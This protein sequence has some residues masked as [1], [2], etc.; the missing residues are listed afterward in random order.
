[1]KKAILPFLIIFIFGMIFI[2]WNKQKSSN[3]I[4]IGNNLIQSTT[5]LEK[6]TE[7]VTISKSHEK[8][9]VN[10]KITKNE[11]KEDKAQPGIIRALE[12]RYER[13][14]DPATGQIPS[15]INSKVAHFL[16]YQSGAIPDYTN[17]D[18]NSNLLSLPEWQKVGPYNIGG[19]TRALAIDISDPE[20]K[21]ILAGAVSGGMWK[22]TDG[23]ITWKRTTEP[24]QLGS[25][26]CI[27]QN[28]HIGKENIWY[29]GTGELWGN[30]ANINGDG[31]FKS[32]DGGWT[33]QQIPS[34]IRNTPNSWDNQFEFI[35]N[36]LIYPKESKDD[37]IFAA[38]AAGGII[39]ST[40]GGKT[41]NFVLGSFGNNS[42]LFTDIASTSDGVLYATLS[43]E[44]FGR[45][46]AS[47]YGIFRSVNGTDWV[48]ITPDNFPE[49]YKRIV[50]GISPSDENQVYFLAETPYS[51]KQTFNTQGDTLWHSLFK[52][53][54][55]SGDGKGSGGQWEDRSQNLPKPDYIRGQFNSQSSYNLVI[56]VKPDNPDIV[57]IGGTNLY[58][59]DDGFKT[60]DRIKW[61]G[62]YCPLGFN[63]KDIYTY[64]NQHA[65]QHA[66][67]FPNNSTIRMYA[68]TDGG[69]SVTENCAADSVEWVS[70]NQGYTTTQFY[71][72]AID[73]GTPGS[74]EII[75][76]TQDNGTL[77]ANNK[78]DWVFAANADG[79]YCAI[80]NGGKYH[81]TSNNS[82]YQPKIRIWRRVLDENGEP[83]ITTRLDPIGGQDFI[84][85]TPF[86]LDP[87]NQN[88]MY[89]AG[90]K[91]VWRN[92]DLSKIPN[93]KNLDSISTEW[94]SLSL[95]RVE[96]ENITALG[97]SKIPANTLY[98][99]TSTGKLFKIKD[100]HIGNPEPEDITGKNFPTNATIGCIAVDPNDGNKIFT[101]FTNYNVE[102]IFYSEDE[103]KT[104]IPVTG[105]LEER[106]GGGGAGPAFNWLEILPL[107][108]G[109]YY[110]AG[111]NSGLFSTAFL[112]GLYTCWVQEA[113]D[114]IGNTVVDMID[115]R[116]SDGFVAVG[117]HGLANYTATITKLPEKP[118]KPS[119]VF[120]PDNAGGIRN[121]SFFV[122]DRKNTAINSKIQISLQPDFSEILAEQDGIFKDSVEIFNLISGRVKHYWRVQTR[123]NGGLSD[124]S[125][126]F[127]FLT[128]INPPKLLSPPSNTDT[129]QNNVTLSWE[130]VPFANSYRLQLS[131]NLTFSSII[132]DTIISSTELT[133]S[134]LIENRRYFWRVAS[135]DEYGQG[136]F[137]SHF[138]FRTK[139]ASSVNL[140][141]DDEF[142]VSPNPASSLI[143]LTLFNE[144]YQNI[145]IELY[146][147]EGRK[148]K[149]FVNNSFDEG[150][151]SLKL[152]ISKINNGI[153]L[154]RISKG[155]SIFSKKILI[156]R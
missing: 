101:V 39:R 47:Q 65:D 60:S 14:K 131:S 53:T 20:Q 69:I 30:S 149:E 61:V 151:I 133:V 96:N 121:S 115:A 37:I 88:R 126:I 123:N 73:H 62:G 153:Y 18:K 68:G 52:Y 125:E 150:T 143:Q 54:Y 58:R 156:Q 35:W 119:L 109:N 122:W 136:D 82:S 84:W 34:T 144:K 100:A 86:L 116:E 11:I 15:N 89:L 146:D 103:G 138:N 152:D 137:A 104:W 36:I 75:G 3:I 51:G 5:G 38:T 59:S 80:E 23:G 63:C 87:N 33:W 49:K 110:L 145:L 114:L 26:S 24:H 45:R 76:G 21:T 77:Y 91:I 4:S 135:I 94:D 106:P 78:P 90:G 67:V 56:K 147:L 17:K 40:D 105:N 83:I 29:Y 98:Y 93:V 42:S 139:S 32:T 46:T 12:W 142:S 112:D 92:N 97:I 85:N 130:A 25:V 22:S 140:T 2:Y 111:T 66:L 70:L 28:P 48:N 50:I 81:Y 27:A 128:S 44:T 129:I 41:W 43:Q 19:R 132:L 55:I 124:F 8:A 64:P 118:L 127:S 95:T 148:I 141:Q 7:F 74:K 79:F 99:G 108:G 107:K 71:T 72:I 117:T 134:N 113:S 102:S 10:N 57:F 155:D 6:P 154:L 9:K 120:P 16:K 13:L 1:M 31:I